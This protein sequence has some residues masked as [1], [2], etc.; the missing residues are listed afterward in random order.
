MVTGVW[1]DDR[2]EKFFDVGH[3]PD[4]KTFNV[5]GYP[6][7]TTPEGKTA[8][9]LFGDDKGG[10]T[11]ERF[12]FKSARDGRNL[13]GTILPLDADHVTR[14]ATVLRSYSAQQQ[15]PGGD[16]HLLNRAAATHPAPSDNALSNGDLVFVQLDRTYASSGNDIPA[17]AR[18]VDVLPTMV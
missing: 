1:Q 13:D 15:E 2:L 11:Y 4:V 9:E 7:R 3:G 17:D 14:Y 12:F 5:W 6:C 18:V 10:K 8:R 16:K